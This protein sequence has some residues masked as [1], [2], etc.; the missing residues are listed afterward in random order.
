MII[1][2]KRQLLKIATIA[3][4]TYQ[5]AVPANVTTK[6]VDEPIFETEQTSGTE[7]KDSY[8]DNEQDSYVEEKQIWRDIIYDDSIKTVL[9][10]NSIDELSDPVYELNDNETLILR[11]DNLSTEIKDFHYSIYRCKK[12]WTESNMNEM[13]YLNGFQDNP[14][15]Y[16]KNSYNTMVP[17]VNYALEFPNENVQLLKSG[18]YRIVVYP[19][20]DPD[21]PIFTKN[22]YVTENTVGVNPK[23]KQ[24]ADIETHDYQQEIDLDLNCG[25]VSITNPY[26]S[27][28]MD[29]TQNRYEFTTCNTLIPNFVREG[30]ITYNREDCNI[31]WGENEF[32]HVDLT[33]VTQNSNFESNRLNM[34]DNTIDLPVDQKRTY[35]KYLE[36]PDIDGKF[37]IRTISGRPED[38][39]FDADYVYVKFTLDYPYE[40]NKEVY[41][42]G[43]FTNWQINDKYLMTFNTE[44]Q[45]YECKVLL[46][47]GYYNY[48]YATV[49]NSNNKVSFSDIEGT[50]YVTQNTYIVK[51]YYSDPQKFYD[52]LLAYRVFNSRDI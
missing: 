46:K 13:D 26:E 24:T 12:D 31:F 4:F 45:V 35:K 21:N 2:K 17:Y 7:Q 37:K 28:E 3:I 34:Y 6:N 41:I 15:E 50:H 30:I 44:S 10:Y 23:M 14:I 25:G 11:F 22:F 49:N 9:L 32:R 5:C 27:I 52:R 43:G 40:T 36:N 19:N 38:N 51:V 20:G 8:Q 29:I 39:H 16:Y 18:N 33:S 1:N 47:Q 48:L 42:T